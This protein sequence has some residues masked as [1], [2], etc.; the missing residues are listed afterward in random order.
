M[1][2][3]LKS[4]KW[5]DGYRSR[6]RAPQA[7]AEVEKIREKNGSVTPAA[8]VKAARAK[9]SPLHPAFEWSDTKA[10]ARY[11]EWEARKLIA[12]LVVVTVTDTTE[13]RLQPAYVSVQLT[14]D[15]PDRGYVRVVD[16]MSDDD[17]RKRALTDAIK[18]L[19]GLRRRYSAL[20]SL[21]KFLDGV[22]GELELMLT[23]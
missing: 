6:V 23:G 20:E 21:V 17:M 3:E 10:A 5:K 18:A 22:E 19:N 14:A 15:S 11:R 13:R 2:A 12:N 8:L 1:S 16:A 9:R 7:L 4:A